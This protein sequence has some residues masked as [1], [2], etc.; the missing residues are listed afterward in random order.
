MTVQSIPTSLSVVLAITDRLFHYLIEARGPKAFMQVV[1]VRAGSDGEVRW[2]VERYLEADGAR[3]VGFDEE[4]TAI[5]EETAVP[6]E[7]PR[8]RNKFGVTAVSGR[9]WCD[10]A[11]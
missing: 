8:P 5:V 2:A 9:I 11:S 3:L 4:E 1:V 7:W 6:P 10:E